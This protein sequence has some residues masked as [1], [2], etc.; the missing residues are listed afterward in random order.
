M[1]HNTLQLTILWNVSTLFL[2]SG[3]NFG[4]IAHAI[5]LAS[6]QAALRGDSDLAI[7]LL[8]PVIETLYDNFLTLDTRKRKVDDMGRLARVPIGSA[9]DRVFRYLDLGDEDQCLDIP[10]QYNHGTAVAQAAIACYETID[11]I[12]WKSVAWPFPEVAEVEYKYELSRFV[13]MNGEWLRDGISVSPEPTGSNPRDNYPGPAGTR[14]YTWK[15]RD[16]DDCEEYKGTLKD[17][18]QDIAK[19]SKEM[20][21]VT[22]LV[23]WSKDASVGQETDSIDVSRLFISKDIRA[24]I[25]TFLNRLVRSYS[26]NAKDRFACDIHGTLET[27]PEVYALKSCDNRSEEDR[28]EYAAS[29]LTLALA[30]RN[31]RAN[32][33]LQCDAYRMV[34]A[35]LP[36]AL[37]GN[38]Q[39]YPHSFS[40]LNRMWTADVIVAK[41]YFYNYEFG[42]QQTC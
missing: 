35:V 1:V 6:K 20:A 16:L 13:T 36:L 34:K 40:K 19:G 2:I 12:D 14:W 8:K 32:T 10:E 42:L 3:F 18:P 27:D 41:Y 29:W 39:F 23:R 22:D 38:K 9:S 24:L 30:A 31:F 15:Y 11:A 37:E 4:N 25:V 5:A 21:F 33:Q 26:G 7:T 17:R 28:P